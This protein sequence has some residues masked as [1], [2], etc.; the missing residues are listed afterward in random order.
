MGQALVRGLIAR[1]VRPGAIRASDP[2]SLARRRLQGW[3]VRTSTENAA[4]GRGADIIVLAVK[5][6]EMASVL[7]QLAPIVG[8]RQLVVSIAAGV[9]LQSLESRL[10]G[11]PVVRVMP[12][13]PAT[14]GKGFSAFTLGRRTTAAHRAVTK[15][16]FEAVGEAVE[17]PERLLDAV[18]A[19]SGSGPAYLFFLAQ[20][21]EEA[22]VRLGL[23]RPVAQ[24]AVRQTLEGSV[25]L[26][27][28]DRLTPEEWIA[29]VA[30]K[31]GTTEAALRVLA[32]RRVQAHIQ[33]ALRAAAA[34]SEELACSLRMS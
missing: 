30:S 5:P 33:E 12:N 10:P 18:T 26:L 8:P 6:Q 27:S 3:G 22:G 19:V 24:R 17:L 13:L 4:A 2:S 1:G 16:I 20:A 31:R 9:T 21:W 32:R 15:A 11:V 25:R 7:A 29:K 28:G 34:R 23:P 14:V